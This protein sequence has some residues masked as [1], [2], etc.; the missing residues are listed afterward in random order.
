MISL[1]IWIVLESLL[2]QR[3]PAGIPRDACVIHKFLTFIVVY[4]QPPV[5]HQNH[6]LVAKIMTSVLLP[7]YGSRW[8]MLQVSRFLYDSGYTCVSRFGGRSLTCN[9]SSLMGSSKI[10]GGNFVWLFF[11]L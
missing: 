9:L 2:L 4:I 5:I 10:V 8:L 7:V 1:L 11:L 6:Q 3:E